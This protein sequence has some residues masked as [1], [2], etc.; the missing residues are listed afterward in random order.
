MEHPKSKQNNIWPNK[1]FP[2]C[3]NSNENSWIGPPNCLASL[4]FKKEIPW[5]RLPR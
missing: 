2:K 4:D 3:E 1:N 5:L